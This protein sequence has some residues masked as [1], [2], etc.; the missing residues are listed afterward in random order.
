M[1]DIANA[2]VKAAQAK[3][4]EVQ[5]SLGYTQVTRAD[6]GAFE[7]GAQVGR[8]PGG[9]QR[10]AAD[11]DLAGRP[12]LGPVLGVGERAA[13]AQPRGRRG[14]ADAAEGQRAT[15]SWCISPTARRWTARARSTSPTRASIRRPAPSRCAP[16]LANADRR[17]E[18]GPVRARE[19]P[20][21]RAPQR[22]R[23]PADRR[24]RRHAG[25]VRLRRRQGQGRQGHR[26]RASGDAGRMG[27]PSTAPTS[28]SSTRAS[29]PA[30][31]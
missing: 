5:L 11:D 31:S 18:A 14:A 19:A 15:T 9:G 24:A 7:P 6:H 23:R 28:G 4:A 29:R 13:P 30:T 12:D 21:R 16:E 3:L 22:A 10:H 26:R 27:R 17:P 1:L 2:S 25:Q 8:Q 20:G